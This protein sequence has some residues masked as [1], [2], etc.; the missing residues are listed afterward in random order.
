MNIAR[1][2]KAFEIK[3]SD[4]ALLQEEGGLWV[5]HWDGKVL[6]KLQHSGKNRE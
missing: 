3:E 1:S 2:S 5:L 4:M 6:K